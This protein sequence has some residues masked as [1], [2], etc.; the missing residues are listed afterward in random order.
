MLI[1]TL[2]FIRSHK[3]IACAKNTQH[4]TSIRRLLSYPDDVYREQ[5][6][7]VHLPATGRARWMRSSAT[8]HYHP[9][10]PARTSSSRGPTADD[11][12]VRDLTALPTATV[13]HQWSGRNSGSRPIRRQRP[14]DDDGRGAASNELEHGVYPVLLIVV[15]RA[16]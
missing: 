10:G 12:C 15:R 7:V 1:I 13:V 3:T 8:S 2:A 14:F 9:A 5:R 11:D 16:F 6:C 4:K